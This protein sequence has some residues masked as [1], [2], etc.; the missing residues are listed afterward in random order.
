[1]PQRYTLKYAS[2][3]LR[4]IL[5]ALITYVTE[6]SLEAV[7]K[8]KR[9]NCV[10][11]NWMWRYGSLWIKHKQTIAGFHMKWLKFKLQNFSVSSKSSWKLIFRQFFF[12][13]EWVLGFVMDYAW[14]SKLLRDATFTW[15]PRELSRWLKKWLISGNLAIWTVLVLEK[16]LF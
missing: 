5:V 3:F 2:A 16:V 9:F 14:I 8:T 1:M 7:W 13:S 4:F 12:Y 6:S 11:S 10:C 15:R